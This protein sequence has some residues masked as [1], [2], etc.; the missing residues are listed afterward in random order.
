[1]RRAAQAPFCTAAHVRVPAVLRFASCTLTCQLDTRS[2]KSPG[3]RA[4]EEN[5]IHGEWSALSHQVTVTSDRD[6]GSVHSLSF[7]LREV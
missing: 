4:E 2:V 6:A 3:E 5:K 1:M 7:R